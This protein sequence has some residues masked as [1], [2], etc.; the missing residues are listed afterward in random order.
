MV[1][2]GGERDGVLS[3]AER[4]EARLLADHH[5]LDDHARA[6]RAEAAGEHHLKRLLGLRERL[7]DDH[8]LPGGEPVRLDDDRRALRPHIGQ[9]RLQRLETRI[10]GGRHAGLVADA[11]GEGLRALELRRR[12]LGPKALIPAAARSSTMP[13]TSG[14]SGPTTTSPM[15]W[16]KQNSIT[17]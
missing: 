13:A 14:P 1:L 2:G 15:S 11:L 8:A 5:L 16:V 9:R 12:R 17:S 6:G 3:I 4:E 7:R 10:G